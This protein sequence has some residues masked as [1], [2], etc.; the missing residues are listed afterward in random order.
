MVVQRSAA[1]TKQNVYF[2]FDVLP[3]RWWDWWDLKPAHL[4]FDRSRRPLNHGVIADSVR[5]AQQSA[6]C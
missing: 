1:L 2:G 3:T 6:V 4:L 5:V